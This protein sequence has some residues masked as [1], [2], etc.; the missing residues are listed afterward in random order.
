MFPISSVPKFFFIFIRQN[1][2]ISNF[3]PIFAALI[4]FPHVPG[5]LL[6]LPTFSNFPPHFVKFTC[7]YI[8]FVFYVSPYFDHDASH[9]A[10]TGL[11]WWELTFSTARGHYLCLS[12]R[13][14]IILNTVALIFSTVISHGAA[15]TNNKDSL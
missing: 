13:L 2:K 15:T 10:R 9:N 8:L 1:F 14:L 7:F 4:H 5:K 6:F 3:F 12:V 11:R